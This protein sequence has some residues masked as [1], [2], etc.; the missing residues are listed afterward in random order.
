MHAVAAAWV[1]PAHGQFA[2]AA[3]QGLGGA[4]AYMWRLGGYRAAGVTDGH[5]PGI[6]DISFHS[7]RHAVSHARPHQ[8][9][10]AC[11]RRAASRAARRSHR[12][13]SGA[14]RM[15]Y[16]VQRVRAA[17]SNPRRRRRRRP[18]GQRQTHAR[19]GAQRPARHGNVTQPLSSVSTQPRPHAPHD[20]CSRRA[21]VCARA[22]LPRRWTS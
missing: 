11:R 22:L 20:C 2:G 12:P 10:Y 21:T 8:Q 18:S 16:R 4:C 5:M 3:C 19:P 13:G 15:R 1:R 7:P 9:R 14:T 6:C 17:P